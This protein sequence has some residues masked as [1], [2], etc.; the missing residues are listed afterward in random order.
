MVGTR[1]GGGG[2]DFFKFTI[3]VE[4]GGQLFPIE[5]KLVK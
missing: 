4:W 5:R 3:K 1:G 2:V